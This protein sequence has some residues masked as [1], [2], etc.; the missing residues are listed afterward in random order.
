MSGK[1]LSHT[2]PVKHFKPGA[3]LRHAWARREGRREGALLQLL[4]V[5]RGALLLELR[6]PPVPVRCNPPRQAARLL[7][8]P[9]AARPSQSQ[10]VVLHHSLMLPAP[11]LLSAFQKHGLLCHTRLVKACQA[12]SGSWRRGVM[13]DR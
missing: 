9:H 2:W 3:H 12:V 5:P 11:C 10:D 13:H 8:L 7:L 4:R 1:Q 6:L